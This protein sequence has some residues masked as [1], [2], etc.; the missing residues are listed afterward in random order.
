M[1]GDCRE[2]VESFCDLGESLITCVME[3]EMRQDSAY[4]SDLDTSFGQFLEY[5]FFLAQYVPQA[6]DAI[7]QEVL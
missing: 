1:D 4:E 2:V 6:M 7:F 5:G 3:A